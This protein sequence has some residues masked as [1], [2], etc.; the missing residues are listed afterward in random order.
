MCRFKSKNV[1]PTVVGLFQYILRGL[2]VIAAKSSLNILNVFIHILFVCASN[3]DLVQ[4]IST[5]NLLRLLSIVLP[6]A[7][8]LINLLKFSSNLFAEAFRFVVF[9]RI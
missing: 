1:A 2:N 9:S 3:S 5:T 7:E 6:N 8:L 4:T